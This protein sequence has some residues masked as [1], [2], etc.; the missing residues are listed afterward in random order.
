MISIGKLHAGKYILSR[1]NKWEY[2]DSWQ[3][4]QDEYQIDKRNIDLAVPAS[5]NA[6]IDFS[7]ISGSIYSNHDLAGKQ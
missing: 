5:L 6:D 1:D 3:N 7:T 4:R 2:Y